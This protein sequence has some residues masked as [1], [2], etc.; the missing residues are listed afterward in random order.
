MPAYIVCI[1]II[2]IIIIMGQVREAYYAL[3]VMAAHQL[4]ATYT[5]ISLLYIHILN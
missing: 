3:F 5:F 4:C 1:I 2:I